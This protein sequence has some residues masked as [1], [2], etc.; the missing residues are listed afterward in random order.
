MRIYVSFL[1]L[2]EQI[3]DIIIMIRIECTRHNSTSTH[4]TF[5]AVSTDT[6]EY[7]PAIILTDIE[8]FPAIKNRTYCTSRILSRLFVYGCSWKKKKT[9]QLFS[10]EN[11]DRS[12]TETRLHEHFK[13]AT[14][15]GVEHTYPRES[16]GQRSGGSGGRRCQPD[17][18]R[19]QCAE[20]L[21]RQ[22]S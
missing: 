15:L 18:G 3:K 19:R 2:K 13:Y 7:F 8:Y 5:L 20:K 17:P 6:I 11:V 10:P 14:E 22:K 9:H 21:I 12:E 16:S 4:R 1:F